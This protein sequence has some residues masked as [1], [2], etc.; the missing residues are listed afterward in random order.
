MTQRESFLATRHTAGVGVEKQETHL[1]ERKEPLGDGDDILHLLNRLDA[2]LD[3]LG[4]LGAGR[5]EDVAD[6]LDV[7]LGPV[8]VRLLDGLFDNGSIPEHSRKK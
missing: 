2:V 7:A 6:A 1:G 3:D 8:P 5:V 4:V